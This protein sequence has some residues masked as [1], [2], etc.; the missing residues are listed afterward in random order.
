MFRTLIAILI[1]GVFAA[2]DATAQ[3]LTIWLD[4]TVPGEKAITK[5]DNLTG[6]SGR[7]MAHVDLAFPPQAVTEDDDKKYEALRTA[8]A[9]GKNRWDEFEVELPIASEIE[10]VLFTIDV[11]RDK[12]DL[13]DVV[14]ARLFQGAA[15]SKAFEPKEF[16]EDE[17]ALPF[18]AQLPG[19]RVNNPWLQAMALDR[20]REFTKAD[21]ADGSAFPELQGQQETILK[22]EDGEIDLS[23]IP[24]GAQVVIDGR[25]VAEDILKYP[26]RPGDHYI[27][28]LRNNT[29]SGRSLVPVA[30]GESV[31]VP[32]A[33]SSSELDQARAKVLTGTTTG[34]PKSVKKAIDTLMRHYKGS[35][36]L[37]AIDH[38]KNKIE[39]LPYA[40]DAS[41]VA[42]R[43]ITVVASGEIGGGAIVSEIFKDEIGQTV[44]A[45][46]VH[47]GLQVEVGIYYGAIIVGSDLAF[48]PDRTV[49][50]ARGVPDPDEGNFDFPILPAPYG[51]LGAYILRPTGDTPTLLI[52]GTYGWNY[53]AHM[54]FGGR[55]AFGIPID[56][57]TWF[58]ISVGGKTSPNV[59]QNWREWFDQNKPVGSNDLEA[60]LVTLFGRVGFGTRF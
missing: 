55:V 41:L 8:V 21:V 44:T 56:D 22:L 9:D 58:R 7:H 25:I 37:A 2:S 49:S 59:S 46:A 4:S 53:P 42:Q 15:A 5:A 14:D 47:A 35:V 20:N 36:F 30:P 6:G 23:A 39:V 13:Q 40:R 52:A 10:G 34:L 18:R 31:E 28:V 17:R 33:V 12:R 48:A 60:P 3:S 45:P 57:G 54:A 19:M 26:V 24:T 29:V 1:G 27:H 38:D 32:L 16:L 11:V 51:G 50:V 43:P